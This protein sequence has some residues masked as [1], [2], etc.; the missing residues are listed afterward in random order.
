MFQI[1]ISLKIK[2]VEKHDY[3]NTKEENHTIFSKKGIEDMK[4][5][6]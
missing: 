1:M 6:L 5:I 3:F 2:Y 4:K